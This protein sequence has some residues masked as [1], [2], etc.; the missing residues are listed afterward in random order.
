MHKSN[1]FWREKHNGMSIFRG[2]A[3][4]TVWKDAGFH[5]QIE[6]L[7]TPFGEERETNP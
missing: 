4:P 7:Y 6:D 1:V 5:R 2:N 3:L